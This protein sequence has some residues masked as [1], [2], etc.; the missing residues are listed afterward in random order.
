M[1]ELL[2]VTAILAI[3]AAL[4]LPVLAIGKQKT[5][6]LSCMNNHRQLT[7]AWQMYAADNQDQLLFA[8]ESLDPDKLWTA[9]YAWVTGTLNYDPNDPRN[10]DP[11]LTIEKT[12][13][14]RMPGKI[15]RSGNARRTVPG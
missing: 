11:A 4:L 1:I 9:K 8:S 12:R 5:A 10:W 14:G 15:R 6:Q 2:V 7:L 3:L 13:C